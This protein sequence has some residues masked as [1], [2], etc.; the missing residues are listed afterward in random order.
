MFRLNSNYGGG[1]NSGSYT[2]SQAASRAESKA[3]AVECQ[4][5]ALRA[6]LARSL[7]ISEALWEL[8]RDRAKL[9]EEDL[10]KKL[11][12]IDMRDGVLDGKN[13]RKAQKCPDCEHMVSSRHPACIY[14]GKVMDD[15]VFSI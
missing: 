5:K 8:L 10:H 1:A 13:Q 3:T 9:T 4:V 15:S 2:G 6:D 7:M 11:Y 12:E 14:C